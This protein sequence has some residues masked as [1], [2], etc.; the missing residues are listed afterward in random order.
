MP[1]ATAR[2]KDCCSKQTKE[3]KAI[4]LAQLLNSNNVRRPDG[5]IR[6]Y[7]RQM[8]QPNLI[9]VKSLVMGN[10][11][12]APKYDLDAKSVLVSFEC[13]W[14]LN[15]DALKNTTNDQ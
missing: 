13:W 8:K 10:L 3:E 9:M 5:D 1:E 7:S 15:K 12:T 14:E 4:R 2:Y 11:A 6:S